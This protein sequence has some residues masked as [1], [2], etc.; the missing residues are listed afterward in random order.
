MKD[1]FPLVISAVLLIILLVVGN[2]FWNDQWWIT[3]SVALLLGIAVSL[4]KRISDKGLVNKN[5]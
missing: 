1:K 3:V 4:G 2:K 5:H